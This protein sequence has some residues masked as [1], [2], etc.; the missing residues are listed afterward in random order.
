[1]FF[2]CYGVCFVL[3]FSF[4]RL[5][6]VNIDTRNVLIDVIKREEKSEPLFVPSR[7]NTC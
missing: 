4:P 6:A 5:C 3:F 2:F 1:M 7:S